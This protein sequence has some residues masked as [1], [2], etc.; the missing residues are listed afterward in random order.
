MGEG[1]FGQVFKAFDNIK[2]QTVAI[3][4]IELKRTMKRSEVFHIMNE[5]DI[6]RVLSEDGHPG[7]VKIFD[8]FRVK[9]TT[10]IVME[11]IEGVSLT[12]WSLEI[13]KSGY[14]LEQKAQP[15][16]KQICSAMAHIHSR[17]IAHRDIKLDNILL[18]RIMNPQS[19]KI[20]WV[21]KIVD[22]GLSD[23]FLQDQTSTDSVGSIA[24]LSPEILSQLPHT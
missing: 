19:R 7:I 18:Q 21:P 1:S 3:K 9:R 5:I 4:S 24:F 16:F 23:I 17:G 2:N 8:V 12:K 14:N 6:M 20:E 15:I 11:Y 22:F 10:Y 13:E